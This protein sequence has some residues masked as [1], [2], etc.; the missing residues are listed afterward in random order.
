MPWR[1][2]R[3]TNGASSATNTGAMY[4]SATPTVTLEALIETK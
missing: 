3:S 1:R 2:V 4:S